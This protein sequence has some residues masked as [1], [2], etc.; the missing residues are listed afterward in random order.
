M[1][2]F[3]RPLTGKQLLFTYLIPIIPLVYAWDGQ[4]S[5]VRMY[6]FEDLRQL[7]PAA[8]DDYVW[9]MGPAPKPDGKHQGYYLLGLPR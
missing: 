5:L 3:V 7:L 6:T 9:E 1:T 8:V 4:A 2:P